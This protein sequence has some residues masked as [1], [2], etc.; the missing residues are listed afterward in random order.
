MGN[1]FRLSVIGITALFNHLFINNEI[2]N[3]SEISIF[4][5]ESSLNIKSN[6]IIRGQYLFGYVVVKYPI[7]LSLF[8]C[9]SGFE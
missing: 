5:F 4:G 8:V 9:K 7:K 1:A 3:A 6:N 2:A